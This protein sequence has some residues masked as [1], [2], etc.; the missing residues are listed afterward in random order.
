MAAAAG[1]SG[2]AAVDGGSCRPLPAAL[3]TPVEPIDNF[4]KPWG[5]GKLALFAVDMPR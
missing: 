4:V 3:R 1:G 5:L 2:T